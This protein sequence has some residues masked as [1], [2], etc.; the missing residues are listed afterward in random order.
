MKAT[1][2]LEG[3]FIGLKYPVRGAL[4]VCSADT[5][6]GTV[7][8]FGLQVPAI[9]GSTTVNANMMLMDG[10][11]TRVNTFEIGVSGGRSIRSK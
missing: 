8:G 6:T 5:R 9:L 7:M 11:K 10:N 4:Y 1:K 3:S 2:C